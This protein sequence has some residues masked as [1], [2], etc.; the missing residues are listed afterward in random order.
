MKTTLRYSVLAV[1]LFGAVVLTASAGTPAPAKNKT[2]EKTVAPAIDTNTFRAVFDMPANPQEGR[3]PFYPK[4]MR[5]YENAVQRITNAAPIAIVADLKLK[6]LSGT[7]D[8]RLA[9][10]NNHTFETGEEADVTTSTGRLK[11]RCLEI[12]TDSVVVQVGSERRELRLRG[13]L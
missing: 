13:V 4:S 6:A 5:P 1:M 10:V 7:P 8:H 2:P 12:D 11:I 3:D 9:L